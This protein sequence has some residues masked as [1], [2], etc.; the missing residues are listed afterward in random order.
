MIF[1]SKFLISNCVPRVF[2]P[3]WM[4]D[5]QLP[6]FFYYEFAVMDFGRAFSALVLVWFTIKVIDRRDKSTDPS[7]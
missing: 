7:V 5:P 6:Y 3:L 4:L 1:Y 2:I